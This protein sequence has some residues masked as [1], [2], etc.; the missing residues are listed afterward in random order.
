M[1]KCQ[2]HNQVLNPAGG[3]QILHKKS[4]VKNN[5]KITLIT[6]DAENGE[7]AIYCTRNYCMLKYAALS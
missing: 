1:K 6:N 3:P 7:C 2:W 4:E 5:Q